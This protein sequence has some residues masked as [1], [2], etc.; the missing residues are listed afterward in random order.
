MRSWS[1]RLLAV[2]ALGAAAALLVGF[3]PFT[4]VQT[5][6]PKCNEKG[7]TVTLKDGKVIICRVIGKNEDGYVLEKYGEIRFAQFLEV[8]G[9]EYEAGVEPRGIGDYD[10]ILINNPEQTIMHGNLIAVVEAG[11]PLTLKSV[12]G[13]VY[14]VSPKQILVYYQRGKRRAPPKIVE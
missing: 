14:L 2:A 12:R 7:D 3:R 13:Q 8:T 11:K 6:C 1:V 9:V 5:V 4:P 10:Q